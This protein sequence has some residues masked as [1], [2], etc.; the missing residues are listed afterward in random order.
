MFSRILVRLL[1]LL[2]GDDH[3]GL[4]IGGEFG[5]ELLLVGRAADLLG[6]PQQLLILHSVPLLHLNLNFKSPDQISLPGVE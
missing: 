4:Q 2:R 3:E 1:F 5:D 6:D